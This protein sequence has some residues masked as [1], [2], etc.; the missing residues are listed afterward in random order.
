MTKTISQSYANMLKEDAIFYQQLARFNSG[1]AEYFRAINELVS[2]C[3]A[4]REAFKCSNKAQECLT[5][6]VNAKIF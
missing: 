4:Q 6:L 2:A 5:E 1:N 3:R